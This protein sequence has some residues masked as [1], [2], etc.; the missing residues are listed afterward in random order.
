[1]R[2]ERKELINQYA[3]QANSIVMYSHTYYTNAIWA[4]FSTS[5]VL[6]FMYCSYWKSLPVHRQNLHTGLHRQNRH[7]ALCKCI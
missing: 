5:T 7:R 6:N 1:M 2:D 4:V 3:G